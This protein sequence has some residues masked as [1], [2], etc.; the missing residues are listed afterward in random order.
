MRKLLGGLAVFTTPV[1]AMAMLTSSQDVS[2]SLR[3]AAAKGLMAAGEKG[4]LEDLAELCGLECGNFAEGEASVTGVGS[5]DAFFGAVLT[6]ESKTLAVEGE[7]KATL[8][9][10]AAIVGVD[11]AANASLDAT[12]DAVVTGFAAFKAQIDGNL[13]LKY[14]PP[15]CSVNIDATLEAKAKCEGSASPGKVEVACKGECVAEASATPPSCDGEVTCTG[16]APSFNCEGTCEGSCELNA[17]AVCEGE[18]RGTCELDG[19]AACD[20]ECQG[21]T[22]NG[23][24]CTGECKL[25]AGA[26][27]EGECKGSCELSGSASCDGACKGECTYNP[28]NATCS[29]EVTCKPGSANATVMCNGECKG[30]VE[31]PMVEVE[32]EATVKAE[33][34]MSAECTPPRVALDYELIT[35]FEFEGAAGV[36]AK[37]A[38]GAKLQAFGE[39]YG[40]L[41]AQ[42]QKIEVI[43]RAS[44][45]LGEAGVDAITDAAGEA[46][47]DFAVT[48]KLASCLPKA[49]SDVSGKLSASANK[50]EARASAIGKVTASIGG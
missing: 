35:D 22:D 14:Q 17:G 2:A 43:L 16:T 9:Q 3:G 26:K 31:P 36:D 8:G 41:L 50:L 30:E 1:A 48:F 5:I 32:C 4:Q 27:C 40:K 7:L 47:G 44:G 33:A 49:L 39:A 25:N 18:C 46:S 19:S 10:M 23:G 20:G 29:G 21:D 45:N 28:G 34:E 13:E 37:A 6:V 42:A 24:N 12:A 11:V 15:Q 38:F